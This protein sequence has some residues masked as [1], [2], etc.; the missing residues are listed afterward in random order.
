MCLQFSTCRQADTQFQPYI[1]ETKDCI[2]E[3]GRKIPPFCPYPYGLVDRIYFA[4]VSQ[5]T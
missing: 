2:Q 4:K 5:K 3:D 1:L